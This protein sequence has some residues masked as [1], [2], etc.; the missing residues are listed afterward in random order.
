MWIIIFNNF[1]YHVIFISLVIFNPY[2][3]ININFLLNYCKS[4]IKRLI[5]RLKNITYWNVYEISI[6]IYFI[7]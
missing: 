1:H 3:G 4:I 7:E 2:Y 5:T 6:L